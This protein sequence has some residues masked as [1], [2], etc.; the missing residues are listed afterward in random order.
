MRGPTQS[1]QVASMRPC[2]RLRP[3]PLRTSP[4]ILPCRR[5]LLAA[6]RDSRRGAPFRYA[7]T[8]RRPRPGL[9]SGFCNEARRSHSTRQ[10]T[11]LEKRIA[12]IPL[13]RFRNFCII[14]HIDHGK[15]TLSDRLLELTG[16]ISAGDENKQVLVRLPNAR[17]YLYP[18]RPADPVFW[19]GL[20]QTRC[21]A[22]TWHHR[23]S[24]DLHH[25]LET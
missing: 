23:Q 11:D 25:D 17:A 4:S 2:L 1:L 15:S 8:V 21:R 6:N 14:A 16:T 5:P 7:S 18:R 13:E 10:V 19:P 24:P 3:R 20:G 22:R 9:G 12:A